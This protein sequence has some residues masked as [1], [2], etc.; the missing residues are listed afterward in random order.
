MSVYRATIDNDMYKKEDWMNKYFIQKP[1]EQTEYFRYHE[2]EDCVTVEIGSILDVIISH[3]DL[4]VTM[5]TE[6]ILADK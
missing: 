1:C 3:G 2:K 6:S 5:S 4:Y